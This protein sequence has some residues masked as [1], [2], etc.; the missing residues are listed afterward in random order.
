[1]TGLGLLGLR[2][3][4]RCCDSTAPG[5]LRLMASMLRRPGSYLLVENSDD[6]RCCASAASIRARAFAILGGAGVD[7]QAFRPCRRPA[8]TCRS[9]PSSAA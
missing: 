5:A 3:R 1:M 2:H 6:L 9:R 7:P 8:T 4:A